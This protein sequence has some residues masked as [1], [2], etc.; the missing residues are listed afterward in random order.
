VLSELQASFSVQKLASDIENLTI[1]DEPD[2]NE[3]S[4]TLVR[5]SGTINEAITAV[6]L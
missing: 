5:A 1:G 6:Y 3:I 2:S 4:V